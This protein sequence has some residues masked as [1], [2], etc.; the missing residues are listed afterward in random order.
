MVCNNGI[1]SRKCAT[2]WIENP[3]G[4]E[5]LINSRE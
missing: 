2:G 1:D 3:E 4:M 5:K